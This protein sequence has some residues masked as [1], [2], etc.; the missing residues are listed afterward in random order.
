MTSRNGEVAAVVAA[1][2]AGQLELAPIVVDDCRGGA[3]VCVGG[4]VYATVSGCGCV[5]V[6]A[7]LEDLVTVAVAEDKRRD[8]ERRGA[9]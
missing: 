9:V 4:L 1:V 5:R 6:V 3:I 7:M 8:S 2:A